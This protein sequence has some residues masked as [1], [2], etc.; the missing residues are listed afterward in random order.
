MMCWEREGERRLHAQEADTVELYLL[1]MQ[2]PVLLHSGELIWFSEA[3]FLN[4]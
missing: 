4:L 2:V 3:F 1:L